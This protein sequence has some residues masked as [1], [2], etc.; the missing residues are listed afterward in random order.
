MWDTKLIIGIIILIICC[1]LAFLIPKLWL[2]NDN[3]KGGICPAPT[4][5][6]VN[7]MLDWLASLDWYWIVAIV[8]AIAGIYWFFI[9]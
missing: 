3:C 4:E 1:I 7:N 8:A 2:G 6:R 5:R 9:K